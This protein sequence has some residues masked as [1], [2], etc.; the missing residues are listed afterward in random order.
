MPFVKGQSGNPAGRKPNAARQELETLLDKTWPVAKR[1][2][3][4]INL[5]TK[6]GNGDIDA[7][8]ILLAYTYGKP[9]ERKE[10]SG[11]EGSAIPL[12]VQH[13][14]YRASLAGTQAGPI[15]DSAAPG[16]D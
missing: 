10:V 15:E 9:I 13:I 5:A 3:A 16:E 6:A 12:E 14:D 7:I 11:P 1:E 4:L 8:K 2:Q